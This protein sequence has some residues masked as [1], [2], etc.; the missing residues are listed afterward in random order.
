[1]AASYNYYLGDEKV[2]GMAENIVAN[3]DIKWET[4]AITDLGFDA[5]FW[6]SRINVTF[7]YFNKI[8]SDILLQLS[9]P[10]TFL[11]TLSAPYQ[12]AGKV[13]NRGWELSATYN[14][15]KGDWGWQAG[16]SLSGVKNKIIDN[17]GIDTYS[18]QTIN[19]EGYAIGSYYG[20]KAIGLYR[21]EA[22]LNR[23]NSQGVVITQNGLTPSLGDIMY[24]DTNDDGNINDDDR[25]I[26]GNP[27]P[28]LSYSFN[29]GA[30]WKNF[31]LTT[32]WQGVA[33][34]YRYNWEQATITNGGNMTTRWLDRWS[35]S[36]PNGSMPSLGNSYNEAYSSFWLDKADYLRLKNIEL[37]Y[38][39]DKNLLRG[40]GIES[41]RLY[42]QA[43]NLLTITSLKNYDPEKTSSDTRG[44]VHP[45]TK[46]F[47]FGVN[48]KF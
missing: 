19:R 4:T 32:F 39:F 16:F 42:L 15:H 9:M 14:D 41:L 47:S 31:D 25:Q 23:T 12:N 43:T 13:R 26:I 11:G 21:T 2:I 38:N 48:I 35:T 1:M 5:A 3:D 24:E 17:K 20:L 6:N 34:I 33:G 44:D 45:N 46:S 27:F 30:S 40:I 7:D 36:N 18:G 10:T 22:D 28:E 29:L 37:G 8:T